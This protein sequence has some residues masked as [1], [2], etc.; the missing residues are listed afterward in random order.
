MELDPIENGA[1]TYSVSG[2]VLGTVATYSC[3]SGF[4]LNLDPGDE[5]RT[6]I[7]GGVGVG[8]VFDGVAPT[9]DRECI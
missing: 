9:C 4:Q 7:D 3:N 6:C 1:I 8:G 2:F 5:M